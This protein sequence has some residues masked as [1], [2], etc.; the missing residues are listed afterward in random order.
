M[1][2]EYL[3]GIAP[4]KK[5]DLSQFENRKRPPSPESYLEKLKIKLL[6]VAKRLNSEYGDF[7]DDNAQI[8]MEGVDVSTSIDLVK[9]KETLW[10]SDI[11]RTREEMLAKREKNSANIAE[12][13]STLLFDKVLHKDFIIVRASTYDDYENGADQLIIDK[14]SGAVICGL[15]DA[16]LGES[17]HDTGEKKANKIN[18][19]MRSGGAQ[20]KYGATVNKGALERKSLH[21][22]PIFYFNINKKDMSGVLESLS[23]ANT[24]LSVEEKALYKQLIDSLLLQSNKYQKDANLSIELKNNINKFQPSLEKMKNYLSINSI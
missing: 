10:A 4:G 8:K 15:D 18:K 20:I 12:I 24:D 6:S 2:I 3:S 19:K 21:N 11:G 1:G 17:I 7:L 16:I 9:S 22:V 13:A 14:Q 5:I 23:S